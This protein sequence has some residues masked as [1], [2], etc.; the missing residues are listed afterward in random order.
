MDGADGG[1]KQA[2]IGAADAGSKKIV[3]QMG[4]FSCRSSAGRVKTGWQATKIVKC[5]AAQIVGNRL[6]VWC[7]NQEIEQGGEAL[8][9]GLI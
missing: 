9:V 7:F 5:R 8:R 6:F 3:G 1:E 4:V 2:G